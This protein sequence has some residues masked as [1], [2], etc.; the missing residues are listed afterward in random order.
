[1]AHP[2]GTLIV[3]IPALRESFAEPR[4]GY[5]VGYHE[6]AHL[7]D[8]EADPRG[9]DHDGIPV[10]L[11][12][13]AAETWARL[14]ARE[15]RRIRHHRSVLRDYGATDAVEFFAVAVETFFELPAELRAS[16]PQ[17]YQFLATYFRQD[18][19]RWEEAAARPETPAPPARQA[20]SV[21]HRPGE[22]PEARGKPARRSGSR[23]RARTPN[24]A[25]TSVRWLVHVLGALGFVLSLGLALLAILAA[26]SGPQLWSVLQWLGIMRPPSEVILPG[27]AVIIA[28]AR[29]IGS[30]AARFSGKWRGTWPTAAAAKEW[31]PTPR[32]LPSARSM[33]SQR[34]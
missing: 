28:P 15:T 9:V 20:A 31:L 19:A 14:R 11:P 18:P 26:V 25:A 4:D 2:S 16:H 8:Q 6:F 32:D 29:S 1:M 22:A 5:H 21:E 24:L 23:V 27:D 7:L 30:D 34:E 10:G 12:G 17:L 33:T 13:R 3:S